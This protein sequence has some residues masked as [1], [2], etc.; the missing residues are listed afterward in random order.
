MQPIWYGF[1]RVVIVKLFF[2]MLGGVRGVHTERVPKKGGLIVAPVHLSFLDPPAVAAAT[3]RRLNFMARDNLFKGIG[4][5]IVRSLGAFPVKRGQV[6]TESIRVAISR[7]EKGEAVLLFPE[8]TRGDGV[9]MGQINRGVSL[10]AKKTGAP[11]LPIGLAGIEKVWPRGGKIKRGR[12]KVVFGQPFTYEECCTGA[13][14][15]ENRELFANRLA[16]ELQ[17]LCLEGGLA[18]Q[19]PSK[20][21]PPSTSED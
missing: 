13:S 16:K 5:A 12:I 21:A 4:G 9:T 8:G 14:E 1:C 18:L 11:V 15:Q 10:I 20:D 17:A 19:V 3:S 2:E 7:I 6:D